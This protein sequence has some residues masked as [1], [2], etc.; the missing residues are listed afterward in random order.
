MCVC[1]V[2]AERRGRRQRTEKRQCTR[3]DHCRCGVSTTT[4]S[5]SCRS[6]SVYVWFLKLH[7]TSGSD[8]VPYLRQATRTH[9]QPWQHEPLLDT[10]R[11]ADDEQHQLT[12]QA[13]RLSSALAVPGGG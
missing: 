6:F 9:S 3:D 12:L 13:T 7:S 11:I 5:S 10:R 8:N 1:Q 4:F 2:C